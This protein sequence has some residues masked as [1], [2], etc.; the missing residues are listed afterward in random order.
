[1]TSEKI[2]SGQDIQD[3]LGNNPIARQ[4]TENYG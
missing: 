1:M 3:I 2:K 4:L